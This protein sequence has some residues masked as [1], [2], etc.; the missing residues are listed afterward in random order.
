MDFE[1]PH[2]FSAVDVSVIIH[3]TEDDNKILQSL[4]DLFCVHPSIFRRTVSLGH[5]GN[6]I[7]LISGRL[8]GASAQRLIQKIWNSL[9]AIER[10]QVGKT[11]NSLID[12][13]GNLY[14]RLDKQ[15]LCQGKISLSESDSVRFRFRPAGRFNINK[16]LNVSE[17]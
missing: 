2:P 16:K 10:D 17:R 12:D 15:R 1:N 5:W 8:D 6:R 13:R 3:A 7:L 11:Q 4:T 9:N 14:V